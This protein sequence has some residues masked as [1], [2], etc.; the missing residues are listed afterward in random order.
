M[1]ALDEHRDTL[2]SVTWSGETGRAWHEQVFEDPAQEHLVAEIRNQTVGFAILGGVGSPRIELRR[3]ALSHE[4][5]GDGLA[6]MLLRALLDRAY[7]RHSAQ[8]VWLHVRSTDEPVLTFYTQEGFAPSDD[9]PAIHLAPDGSTATLTA[10][11]HR[12]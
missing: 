4:W 2:R 10:L 12:R 6:R 9:R 11:T 3:V 7:A 1:A 5:R 8:Q